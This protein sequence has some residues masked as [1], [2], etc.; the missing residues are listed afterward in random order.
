MG[1]A[2]LV[3]RLR[4][5]TGCLRLRRSSAPPLYLNLNLSLNLNLGLALGRLPRS[6]N[7]RVPG[8]GAYLIN[9]T[10]RGAAVALVLRK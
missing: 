3:G 2:L 5:T 9:R 8:I 7:R 1:R 4:L 6:P 10:L